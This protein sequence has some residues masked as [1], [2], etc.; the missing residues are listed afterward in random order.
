MQRIYEGKDRLVNLSYFCRGAPEVEKSRMVFGV[1]SK[2][3][4]NSKINRTSH[5]TYKGYEVKF[6]R[7]F[8]GKK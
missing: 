6:P 1:K 5:A 7:V 3:I 8:A 4:I 2:S